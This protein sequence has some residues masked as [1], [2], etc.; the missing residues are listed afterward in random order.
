MITNHRPQTAIEEYGAERD[1]ADNIILKASTTVSFGD[2]RGVYSK[3][4]DGADNIIS[5]SSTTPS[6][7]DV[8]GVYSKK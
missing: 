6:F 5:K 7:G 3:K 1:R 4:R 8:R 2:V